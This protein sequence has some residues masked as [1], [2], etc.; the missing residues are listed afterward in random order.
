MP[1]KCRI[2][3]CDKYAKWTIQDYY[4]IMHVC[5]NHKYVYSQYKIQK[6]V[7]CQCKTC[8]IENP[9]EI[10]EATF[11]PIIN[12]RHNRTYCK[13]HA[14]NNKLIKRKYV[15]DQK[16]I[17]SHCFITPSFHSDDDPLKRKLYCK[18]H[19]PKTKINQTDSLIN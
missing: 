1:K 5:E 9:N 13:A 10:K 6:I 18:L 19:K 3:E 12:G 14:P 16:C 4:P 2:Y 17:V 15:Q 8:I 7:N 11:G